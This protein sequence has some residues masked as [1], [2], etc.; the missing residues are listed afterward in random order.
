MSTE[1]R[2]A[3]AERFVERRLT[4]EGYEII[5]TNYR[6]RP[7][8]IDIIALHDGVL[9]FVEVK[10]RTGD[11]YG[12]VDESVDRRKIQRILETGDVFVAEHPEYGDHLWRLDL[13]AITLRRD[14]EIERFHHY[15][16]LIID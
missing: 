15:E 8:E 7:G 4:A 3:A 13:V 2:G 16:D 14:G 10:Q 9:V 1:N 6:A 5:A 12:S 11:R